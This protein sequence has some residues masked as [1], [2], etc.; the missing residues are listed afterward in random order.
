[1]NKIYPY[2]FFVLGNL[3]YDFIAKNYNSYVHQNIFFYGILYGSFLWLLIIDYLTEYSS[4]KTALLGFIVFISL[5]L[6]L[7]LVCFDCT[8][9]EFLN[10][11]NNYNIDLT[12]W[13]ILSCFLIKY[14][15]ERYSKNGIST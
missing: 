15:W 10:T 5:R 3:C 11:V 14:L 9:N 2:C 12:G 13:V 8:K 4:V 1:M 6:S 7:F